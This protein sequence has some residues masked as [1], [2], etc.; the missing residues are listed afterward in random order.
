MTVSHDVD[1]KGGDGI[2]SLPLI[3]VAGPNGAGKSIFFEA[4]AL[5]WRI[6]SI[7][8]RQQIVPS[9]IIGPWGNTAQIDVAVVLEEDEVAVLG[10]YVSKVGRGQLDSPR[11]K[12]QLRIEHSDQPV[13]VEVTPG[14]RAATHA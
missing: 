8:E 2:A 6:T 3:T 1:R 5:M 7:W 13:S 10:E 14:G 9:A 11:A 4:I 12:M